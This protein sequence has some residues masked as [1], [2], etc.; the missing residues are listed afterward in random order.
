[1]AG[2][3]ELLEAELSPYQDAAA[4]IALDGPDVHLDARAFSVLALVLHEL[5][6]NAAKYGA[7]SVKSGLAVAA[8]AAQRRRA[9]A[10]SA[11]WSAT[12]RASALTAKPGFGSMLIG[13]SIP[14]DLGG[15]SE[16]DYE[17][18]GARVQV[19]DPRPLRDLAGAAG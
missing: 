9:T 6:T 3:R 15:D 10:R 12:V 18:E 14:Y 13:R 17:A 1:V 11:G 2:L 5:A 16:V 8:V 7:L 19:A 4:E